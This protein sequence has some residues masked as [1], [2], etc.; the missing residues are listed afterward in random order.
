MS[1]H[2]SALELGIEYPKGSGARRNNESRLKNGLPEHSDAW[3]EG[4]QF[5]KFRG[6]GSE[7]DWSRN[8]V[9]VDECLGPRDE[10]DPGVEEQMMPRTPA[11]QSKVARIRKRAQSFGLGRKKSNETPE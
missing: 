3:V 10:K 4:A 7:A 1:E 11:R 6:W 2:R 5:E 9:E 8:G